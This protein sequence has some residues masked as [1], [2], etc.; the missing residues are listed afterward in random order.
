MC[1]RARFL[2]FEAETRTCGYS[3]CRDLCLDSL[4]IDKRIK[5]IKNIPTA[6]HPDTGYNWW[7][8]SSWK[9]LIF[10]PFLFHA[11]LSVGISSNSSIFQIEEENIP[12][13]LSSSRIHSDLSHFFSLLI[14]APFLLLLLLWSRRNEFLPGRVNVI[15]FPRTNLK[16]KKKKRKGKTLMK[17]PIKISIARERR[18]KVF[19]TYNNRSFSYFSLLN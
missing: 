18:C 13:N 2:T 16:K 8:L 14:H 12:T 19:Y 10:P 5:E 4:C 15:I 3:E 9:D 1:C 7:S 6:S 17:Y 11:D